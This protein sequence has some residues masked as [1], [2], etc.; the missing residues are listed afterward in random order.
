MY[1]HVEEKSMICEKI[2]YISK[3]RLCILADYIAEE[4]RMIC[5]KIV[6][7]PR[8]QLLLGCIGCKAR[9]VKR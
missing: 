8:E 5:E 2:V 6:Y 7:I 1:K 3:Q 4:K 9:P